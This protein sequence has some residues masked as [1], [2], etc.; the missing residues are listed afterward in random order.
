MSHCLIPLPNLARRLFELFP[1]KAEDD[2]TLVVETPMPGSLISVAVSV[3]DSVF[4][5]QEVAVVEAMKMQ[6]MLLA[7]RTGTIKAVHAEAGATLAEGD[8]IL[9]FV[10]D[11]AV[12]SSK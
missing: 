9:E 11:T 7:P 3:G 12:D 6:N 1:E 4:E 2:K 10:D 5:G 8:L